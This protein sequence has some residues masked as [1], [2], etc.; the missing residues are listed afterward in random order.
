MC[1]KCGMAIQKTE[2]C[3]K[4]TCTNCLQHFCYK[5]N[6]AVLDYDHFRD[7][8]CMLFDNT[9]VQ[10]WQN[11][12]DAQVQRWAKITHLDTQAHWWLSCFFK[13]PSEG[14][15]SWLWQSS[16]RIYAICRAQA[17]ARNHFW[18]NVDLGGQSLPCPQCGQRNAKVLNN[19]LLRCWVRPCL[20]CF[21]W[22]RVFV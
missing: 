20:T 2:G 16:S 7:G 21:Y 12:W 4:M 10:R 9:E 19:N 17:Q 1:P 15:M 22:T 6:K 3:N 13:E 8:S 5:C 14:Q 18:L 11:E